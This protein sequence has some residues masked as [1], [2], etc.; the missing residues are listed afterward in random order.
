M[1]SILSTVLVLALAACSESSTGPAD[2]LR[3]QTDAASYGLIGNGPAEVHFTVTNSGST[4]V[5][6]GQC[7]EGVIAELQQRQGA[8]WVTVASGICQELALYMPLML[9]PGESAEG[10]LSINYSGRFRL[11]I[12]VPQ[13]DEEAV[14]FANSSTFEVQWLE[15]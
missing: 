4:A 13:G 14:D 1:R 11:R 2:G 12:M 8:A 3:V 7:S 15:D 10:Q 9:A 6:I 5:G